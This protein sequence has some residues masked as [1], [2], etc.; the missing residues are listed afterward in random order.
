MLPR[1]R[2]GLS[3]RAASTGL[4]LVLVVY[5][6]CTNDADND[7][8]SS[9]TVGPLTGAGAG[10]NACLNN[11]PDGRCYAPE[12]C[13]CQDCTISSAKCNDRCVDDGTC[14]F[15]PPQDDNPDAPVAEDCSCADCWNKIP[16]CSPNTA[17]N[18]DPDI[19]EDSGEALHLCTTSERCTCEDCT[20]TP[21][22][23][24][25]CEDNGTCNTATEGCACADCAG[26]SDCGGSSSPASST[27]S[28]TSSSTAAST[29]S[30]GGTG[31]MPSAGGGGAGGN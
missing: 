29:T 23:T 24:G 20:D 19:D 3:L 22:C 10:S 31:G 27:S 6:G 1:R 14:D 12:T 7:A 30:T 2:L 18:C 21:A 5:V 8:A 28:S 15:Q 16:Q 11:V 25:N 9:T 26:H 4:A 17:E 13:A